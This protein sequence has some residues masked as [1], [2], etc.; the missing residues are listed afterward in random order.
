MGISDLF[1]FR[2]S[3]S[4]LA[5]MPDIFPLSLKEKVFVDTDTLAIYLKIITDV[6][7]RT[8]GLPEELQSMLW[9]SCLKSEAPDGLVSLL[10]KAMADKDELFLVYNQALKLLKKASSTESTQIKADYA[11]EGKSSL[12]VYI[13]F[14]NYVRTDMVKLYSGLEYCTVASLNKSMK[15]STAIQIKIKELRGNVSLSDSAGATTQ[16]GAIAKNLSE[17]KDVY[18]DAEDLI[19]TSKPELSPIKE[20]MTFLNQKKSF[21]LG[22]PASYITGEAPKG[23]GDS[24]EGDSK[25]VERGLKNYYFSIVKPVLEV[26]FG[27]TTTF[28]S[29]DF[30]QISSALESLKT[31]EL[32]SDDLISSEEKRSVVSKLL[33]LGDPKPQ[34]T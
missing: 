17:G 14:K 34:Q 23:L 27:S 22:M 25:A 9:D 2:S 32:V 3:S 8:H 20:A 16:A 24:G 6:M 13:S 33:D 12:G 1:N 19:E 11:K 4:A 7:E 18:L 26:L 30:R 15:L 31:F 21:H 10:A 28:K 29:Q 5:E